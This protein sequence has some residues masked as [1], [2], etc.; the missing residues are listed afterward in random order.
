MWV[1][2]GYCFNAML[3]ES[4]WKFFFCCCFSGQK[5]VTSEIVVLNAVSLFHAILFTLHCNAIF[6]VVG[7]PRRRAPPYIQPAH[8]REHLFRPRPIC[9]RNSAMRLWPVRRMSVRLISI[10]KR[11]WRYG[12][13]CIFC[14]MYSFN[15]II[16]SCFRAT[17]RWWAVNSFNF[18]FV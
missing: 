17:R 1:G 9:L 8:H 6:P 16:T 3:L 12:E 5:N 4:L 10:L 2:T 7:I 14:H 18:N 13:K 11:P 15:N